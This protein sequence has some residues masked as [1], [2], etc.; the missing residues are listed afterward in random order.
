MSQAKVDKYKE[1][2]VHR[3]EDVKKNRRKKV[4]YKVAGLVICV[5]L[6]GWIGYSGVEHYINSRPGE[7]IEV[8][9]DAI[10]N[11]VNNIGV[12]EDTAE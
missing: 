7:T 5:G 8:K 10:D 9:Y 1:K 6:I 2:K 4:L 3:K 11:Y 12:T